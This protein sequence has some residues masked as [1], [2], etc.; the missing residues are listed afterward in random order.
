MTQFYI[1]QFIRDT[2]VFK[3]L[4]VL[5]YAGKSNN[6]SECH[7][8]KHK[9]VDFSEI[10]YISDGK[11]IF[12][13][14]GEYYPVKK[15]DILVYNKDVFHEEHSDSSELLK[16]YYCGVGNVYLEGIQEKCI[17]P[18][19]STPLI[20]TNA[21]DI[22]GYISNIFEECKDQRPGYATICQSLLMSLIILVLRV[23]SP[24]NSLLLRQKN[25]LLSEKIKDYIDENYNKDITLRNIADSCYVSKHY[26]SHLF[27]EDLGDS[28]INYLISRR[29]EV[30][31]KL[32][33]T[34]NG[35]IQSIS[36][37]VGYD[38]ANYFNILFK[39]ITGSTPGKFRESY[40][41]R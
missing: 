26:L 19:S 17:I 13:I 15:G 25:M 35:N 40:N 6:D 22:E 29:I 23:V 32:L 21:Y 8:P 16:T 31:K 27:K 5:L 4:P 12:I 41:V 14:S 28:P 24:D 3:T 39:K 37:L 20:S 36:K 18:P 30:A 11:G 2:I 38:N 7:F 34:T 9:H 1:N 10:V 33:L